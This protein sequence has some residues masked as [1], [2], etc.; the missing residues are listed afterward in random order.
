VPVPRWTTRCCAPRDESPS[1]TACSPSRCRP[2][3]SA[4]P[5]WAGSGPAQQLA[6]IT[7]IVADTPDHV[8]INLEP[9][10]FLSFAGVVAPVTGYATAVE[11]GT[12]YHVAGAHG[13]VLR[14]LRATGVADVLEGRDDLGSL[15][16]A[17][18]A[19]PGAG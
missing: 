18:L 8:L 11:Y 7:V 14:L 9:A 17:L 16:L 13:E 15:L 10:D 3:W 19:V 4:T 1:S 12:S 6:I 2:G 5:P